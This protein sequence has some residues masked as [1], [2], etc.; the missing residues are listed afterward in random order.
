M[1]IHFPFVRAAWLTFK[2]IN[3]DIDWKN[4]IRSSTGS[5]LAKLFKEKIYSRSFVDSF[6]AK[7][8]HSNGNRVR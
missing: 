5:K 7:S 6:E 1:R 3:K 4:Q 2:E 8:T